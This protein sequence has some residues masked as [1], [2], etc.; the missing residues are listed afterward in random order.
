MKRD[1]RSRFKSRNDEGVK[2]G[3]KRSANTRPRNDDY[4]SSDSEEQQ[5]N[6]KKNKGKK[7]RR[8]ETPSEESDNED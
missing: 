8:D 7:N 5:R 2:E 3:G 6:K 4:S 1:P